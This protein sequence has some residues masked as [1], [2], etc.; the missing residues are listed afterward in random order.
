MSFKDFEGLENTQKSIEPFQEDEPEK[1]S[2]TL[3][4]RKN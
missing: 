1:K 2:T 4:T 3:A